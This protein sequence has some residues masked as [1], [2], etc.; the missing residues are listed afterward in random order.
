MKIEIGDGEYFIFLTLLF[1]LIVFNIVFTF[2][3]I[4]ELIKK[5][6]RTYGP[7]VLKF[8]IVSSLVCLALFISTLLF[9]LK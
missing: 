3:W 6:S 4:V 1:L 5:P 8:L 7:K 9:I 2:A